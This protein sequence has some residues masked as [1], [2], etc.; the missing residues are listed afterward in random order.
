MVEGFTVIGLTD[1]LRY[2]QDKH[3]VRVPGSTM[4]VAIREA[5]GNGLAPLAPLGRLGPSWAYDRAEALS[6]VDIHFM[7]WHACAADRDAARRAEHKRLR[8][9]ADAARLAAN[10]R[11]LAE[12]GE[13]YKF[14]R[15]AEAE[16]KRRAEQQDEQHRKRQA[17]TVGG[18]L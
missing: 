14:F 16:N 7:P 3:G 11:E 10:Q 6:W 12:V 5:P 15:E 17:F 9:Q 2:I 8:E 1:I 13:R 4:A 18:A